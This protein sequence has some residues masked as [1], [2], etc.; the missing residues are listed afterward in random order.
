VRLSPRNPDDGL[1]RPA[2]GRLGGHF[3]ELFT[4]EIELALS[5]ARA[6]VVRAATVASLGVAGAIALVASLVVLLAGGLAPVFGAPWKHL[7]VAGASV[8]L[9]SCAAIAWS[10]ARLSRLAPPRETLTSVEET[11]QWLAAELRSRLT[12]RP[13]AR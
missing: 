9:I 7:V 8:F 4:L 2:I 10:A 3:R 5:E 6:F 13:R 1:G 12:L 11:L